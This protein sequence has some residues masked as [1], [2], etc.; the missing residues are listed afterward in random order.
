MVL[1]FFLYDDRD[2]PDLVPCRIAEGTSERRG[3]SACHSAGGLKWR[4]EAGILGARRQGGNRPA[5]TDK[6]DS[7][8]L[9]RSQPPI[10]AV[11][12][13]VRAGIVRLV[14]VQIYYLRKRTLSVG[15]GRSG[16]GP[17]VSAALSI[18]WF[19]RAG[20]YYE[21]T[22]AWAEL[23]HIGCMVYENEWNGSFW[24]FVHAQMSPISP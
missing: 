12:A 3:T 2:V 10:F 18:G 9:L 13:R 15:G 7:S 1:R 21:W 22:Q 4:R 11:F 23:L 14:L 16:K 8:P 6:G 20:R 17:L 19:D 24:I 5:H